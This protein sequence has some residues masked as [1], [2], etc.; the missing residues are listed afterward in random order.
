M[1]C[2][3]TTRL[4]PF[5]WQVKWPKDIQDSLVTVENPHG[6]VTINDLELAG[7]LLGFL[8]LESYGV[9]LQYCHLAMF[10]DNMMTVVWAYKLHNSKSKI[11]G[12]L[13]HFLGLQMHQAEC[14]SMVPHHIAG[15][16]NIMADIISCTFNNGKYFELSHDLV[17]YF[18]KHFPLV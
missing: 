1:W 14:S 16:D 13:L 7:A 10:C 4:K 17:S 18:N 3:G 8:V 15:E 2:S 12:Y 9:P 11:V 5:L 6:S